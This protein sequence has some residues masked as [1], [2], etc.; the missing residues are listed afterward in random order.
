MDD[1]TSAMW[2]QRAAL[3]TEQGMESVVAMTIDRWFTPEFLAQQHQ[4]IEAVRQTLRN[5]PANG[6]SAAAIALADMHLQSVLPK[7]QV[8]TLFISGQSDKAISTAMVEQYAMQNPLFQFTAIP[9]P[10]ILNLENQSGFDQA[11]MN[12]ISQQG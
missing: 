4:A 3:V 5:T 7:L 9:G 6:F 12:F 10:H 8:P 11:V 2:R 1:A